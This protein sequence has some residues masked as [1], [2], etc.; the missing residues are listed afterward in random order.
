[1][2]IIQGDWYFEKSMCKDPGKLLSATAS[3]MELGGTQYVKKPK[4][5]DVSGDNMDEGAGQGSWIRCGFRS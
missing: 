3:L 2:I 1:M 5:K 4:E